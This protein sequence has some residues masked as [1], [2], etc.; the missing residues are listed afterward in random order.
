MTSWQK[1]QAPEMLYYAIFGSEPPFHPEWK[2][3]IMEFSMKC[4]NWLYS[5]LQNCPNVCMVVNDLHIVP[6]KRNKISPKVFVSEII[7]NIFHHWDSFG[8]NVY[9][10]I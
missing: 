4:Q 8:T 6:Q 2:A 5:G 9:S 10:T 3:F 1:S 7:N